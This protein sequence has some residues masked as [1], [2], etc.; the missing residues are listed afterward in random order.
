[1]AEKPAG[2]A[3]HSVG[4]GQPGFVELLQQELGR[5]LRVCHRLDKETSGAIVLA[6]DDD[7]AGALC[8]LFEAREVQKSYLFVSDR[9]L[10]PDR[11]FTVRSH[12]QKRRGRFVS[13]LKHED[14]N[15]ETTIAFH[16]K[17]G[18]YSL[19]YAN[20]RT[21]KPHQIRLHA[22]NM[23][24][25]ILGD[26][27]HAGTRFERLMLHAEKITFLWK[28]EMLTHRVEA[29]ELLEKWNKFQRNGF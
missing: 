17:R 23:G 14:L 4:D 16:E 6:L 5:K 8:A 29:S 26:S 24:I 9:A 2:I 28:G 21:G 7:S 20:P 19:W 13:W 27:S 10:P 15:S 11:E 3:T 22:W 12:I 18:K 25:P 1:M